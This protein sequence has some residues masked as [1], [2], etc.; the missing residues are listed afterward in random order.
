[1]KNAKDYLEYM[2]DSRAR[3]RQDIYKVVCATEKDSSNDFSGTVKLREFLM[4]YLEGFVPFNLFFDKDG[5]PKTKNELCISLTGLRRASLKKTLN[6]TGSSIWKVAF[7]TSLGFFKDTILLGSASKILGGPTSM[8]NIGTVTL[9]L[10]LLVGALSAVVTTGVLGVRGSYRR[11]ISHAKK[12][13]SKAQKNLDKLEE[14]IDIQKPTH[15]F[16]AAGLTTIEEVRVSMSKSP[17][18]SIFI[19]VRP[20]GNLRTSITEVEKAYGVY[21]ESLI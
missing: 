19:L 16:K 15:D 8:T 6:E 20:D 13:M 5:S 1:M 10:A 12:A 21:V 17:K 3:D 14:Q 11:I 4:L 7:G 18:Y 2:F 9:P